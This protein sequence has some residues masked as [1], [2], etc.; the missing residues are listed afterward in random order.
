MTFHQHLFV[1]T[2]LSPP[3]ST[4][5]ARCF[6]FVIRFEDFTCRDVMLIVFLSI[7]FLNCLYLFKSIFSIFFEIQ[8]I[9]WHGV[10][11]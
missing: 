2:G 7:I 4:K 1:P 9:L 6:F 10:V 3:R 5:T 8:V 11:P